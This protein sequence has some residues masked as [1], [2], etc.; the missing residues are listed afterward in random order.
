MTVRTVTSRL[1]TQ[2]ARNTSGC[3][4]H[5]LDTNRLADMGPPRIP[6]GLRMSNT[7]H[8]GEVDIRNRRQQYCICI[9]QRK[10]INTALSLGR[11]EIRNCSDISTCSFSSPSVATACHPPSRGDGLPRT[12]ATILEKKPG[13]DSATIGRSSWPRELTDDWR[14]ILAFSLLRHIVYWDTHY[15]KTFSGGQ[16]SISL[17]NPVVHI[18]RTAMASSGAAMIGI[19]SK[20][21]QTCIKRGMS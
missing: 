6:E 20:N 12:R 7:I 21:R 17:V 8:F 1:L 18:P 3:M 19:Q 11:H 5:F 2:V 16:K 10:I 13:K 15:H 14:G 4:R 9:A